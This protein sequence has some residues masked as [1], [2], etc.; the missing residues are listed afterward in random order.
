MM[1]KMQKYFIALLLMLMTAELSAQ[2]QQYPNVLN[3]ET[4][5]SNYKLITPTSFS[6]LGA[7]HAYALPASPKDQ[8]GFIGPMVMDMNGRWLANSFAQLQIVENGKVIDLGMARSSQQ[9]FPG[10]MIQELVTDGLSIINQLIFV[11]SREA[12]IQT[13]VVNKSAKARKLQLSFSGQTILPGSR[14]QTIQR[15]LMVHFAKD[16]HRFRIRYEGKKPV[17]IQVKDSS[18]I[19]SFGINTIA[20][21]KTI[22]LRQLQGFYPDKE[23]K[24]QNSTYVF[25]SEVRKNEQ[26]WNRYLHRYFSQAGK[27]SHAEKRLAVKSIVTLL[28]N[29]RTAS[30][31][32]LHD[33]VFPSI[34]YQGFYG[35]WSWDSWKQAVALACIDP[36]IAQDNILCMFDYQDKAGMVP[37][38]IYSDKTENNLRDTKP[39]L[40]SWGVWEVFQQSKDTAFLRK[41]YPKL[42]QYHQWW[43]ANRDHDQNGWCEF[44]STDGTRIAAA[45]ESGMDNAV[46]FDSAVMIKNNETAWSLNQESVDLNAYLLQEKEFLS[47]IAAELGKIDES[48]A[49]KADATKGVINFNRDFFDKTKGYY[50]D[51]RLRSDSLI[52]VEGTEGWTPLWAGIATP[53]EAKN[54]QEVMMKENKF[55]TLLPMPTLVADH[56]DFDPLKGYWRGP[57]WLDQFYFGIIGLK[58]YGFHQEATVLLQKLWQHAD[59]LFTDSPIHENYHPLTGKGLNARNF[60]WSAAHLLLLLKSR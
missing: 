52:R 48:T 44:G 58:R 1:E 30:K 39:P 22:Y 21:G 57:V 5:V 60:S 8:G 23:E 2:R 7:W 55:N 24:M 20:P 53:Q 15:G 37:D 25:E 40:A 54:V 32:L 9:Y 29:W 3:L 56:P 11:S 31:D 46:R 28:T 50:Y 14:L 35:V 42:K 38:C 16:E 4:T 18:Y 47:T 41:M 45:W 27:L 12:M 17:T 49:W 33:G 51:K 19:A 13:R 36:T 43:Y 10:L 6:D 26:R 59:G 34:N